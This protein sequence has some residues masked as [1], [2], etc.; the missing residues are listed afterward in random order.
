MLKS[1]VKSWPSSAIWL[2]FRRIY[3]V[4]QIKF[5]RCVREFG[6][7]RFGNP[8]V[9][10]NLADNDGKRSLSGLEKRIPVLLLERYSRSRANLD[11][12]IA[13]GA[14]SGCPASVIPTNKIEQSNTSIDT[15]FS[16]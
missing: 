12:D 6:E 8:A 4:C 11:C 2:G 15:Y 5:F 9:D 3:Q 14:C 13:A 1:G 16:S 7:T 10:A